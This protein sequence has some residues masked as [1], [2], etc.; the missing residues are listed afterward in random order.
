MSCCSGIVDVERR[1]SGVIAHAR[2]DPADAGCFGL[3]D[4]KLG[5]A[6]HHQMA[7]A[8]VAVDQRRRRPLAHH[9]D[10]R[11]GIDAAGADA[12]HVERQPDHAMGVGAAQIGLDHEPGKR[13]RIVGRQAGGNESAGDK[14]REPC[15]RNARVVLGHTGHAP[16]CRMRTGLAPGQIIRSKELGR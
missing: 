9:A 11:L 8:V 1:R 13:V 4:R 6:P 14:R 3:F 12:A 5:G 15:G 10:I 7:H 2:A 16:R